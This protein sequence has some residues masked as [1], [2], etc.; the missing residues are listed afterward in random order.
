[1]IWSYA[2]TTQRHDGAIS[3]GMQLVLTKIGFIGENAAGFLDLAKMLQD[4]ILEE[5]K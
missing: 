3:A 4:V 5:D 1:M 2:E